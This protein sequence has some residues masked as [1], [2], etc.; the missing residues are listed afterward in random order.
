M[1]FEPYN[2]KAAKIAK[3]K[4][5]HMVPL[6]DPTEGLPKLR[7]CSPPG[8]GTGECMELLVADGRIVL[9]IAQRATLATM[10]LESIGADFAN[11]RQKYAQSVVADHIEREITMRTKK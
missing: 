3:R 11:H 9:D 1:R 6:Y 4:A 2:P 8:S 7:R 10:L 5:E